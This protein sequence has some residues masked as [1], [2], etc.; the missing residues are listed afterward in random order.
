MIER[1]TYYL[2]EYSHT[3]LNNWVIFQWNLS[4]VCTESKHKWLLYYWSK[5]QLL[6]VE[7]KQS[8]TLIKRW[9][10]VC[11]ISSSFTTNC[12]SV[13]PQVLLHYNCAFQV[14]MCELLWTD[15]HHYKVEF[16]CHVDKWQK[17]II[18]TQWV[19]FY[20]IYFCSTISNCSKSMAS[21]R[22]TYSKD[23]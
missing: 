3:F 1:I 9:R 8:W 23:S 18:R 15:H 17:K 11:K 5:V 12:V 20:M 4:I 10:G 19:S 14:L 22:A 2:L 6:S 13:R 21:R 7:V 16:D